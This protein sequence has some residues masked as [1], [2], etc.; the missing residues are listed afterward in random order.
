MENN[1]TECIFKK[2]CWIWDEK[3]FLKCFFQNEFSCKA[4]CHFQFHSQRASWKTGWCLWFFF[5]ISLLQFEFATESLFSGSLYS[6][7][8]CPAIATCCLSIFLYTAILPAWF[9]NLIWIILQ[10]IYPLYWS[11]WICKAGNSWQNFVGKE[12]EFSAFTVG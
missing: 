3:S 7:N 2:F 8:S 11:K 4:I 12:G 10:K 9:L 5:L 1:W 6:P